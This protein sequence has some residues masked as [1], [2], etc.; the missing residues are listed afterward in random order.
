MFTFS[1]RRRLILAASLLAASS[2]YALHSLPSDSKVSISSSLVEG[3]EDKIFTDQSGRQISLRGFNVSG[4]VKLAESGFKAFKTAQDAHDSLTLLRQKTGANMIRYTIA[5]EGVQPS[6][7]GVDES[8]LAAVAEQIAIAADLGLYVLIDYH[9]DLY[10]RHTFTAASSDTGNGAPAWAVSDVYGKDD[11]G[12]PCDLTWA[13][14]KQSDS[15]VRNAMRS[16]WF[17]HWALNQD[18]ADTELFMADVAQ[19]VDVSSAAIV[20]DANIITWS[21]HNAANQRWHYHRDATLRSAADGNFCIDAAGGYSSNGT[22]IQLYQ[23][24]SSTA[25]KF[26]L[27]RHGRLHSLLDLNKCITRVNQNLE[28]AECD[29]AASAAEQQFV[30]RDGSSDAVLAGDL[31]YVQ[32]QFVWQLGEMLSYLQQHLTS[33]QLAYIIGVDPI[34]EPFDGGTGAMSYA[35][36]DNYVLWPF[37]EKVRAEMDRRGWSGTPVYAEPNV[38]WSSIAG[39][40]APATGGHYLAYQPGDGFVF[41]SHFY[42][43]G[44]MGTNDLSVARNGSYFDNLDLI[45]NEARY[46]N[47]APF[48]SEFGMWLDGW[49]HT[50]TSRIVNATYQG[51]ESS[52]SARSKD[53]YLNFYTPLISGSQ[54]QWDYYYDNHYELQNGNEEQV[55]TE[56]DA[57]NGENFSVIA[58]YGQSYNLDARLLERAYPR[59]VQGRLLHFAYSGQVPDEAG[60]IMNWYSIRASLPGYFR[61]REFLR[62]SIFAF[63]AWRGRSSE[64]PTEIYWPRHRDSGQLTLITERLIASGSELSQTVQ[65]SPDEA[66][67]VADGSA[68]GGQRLLVWDDTSPEENEDSLHFALLID[69]T[70]LSAS[71]LLQL[72]QAIVAT[73]ASE[74]SPVYLTGAMTHSGYGEDKGTTDNGFVLVNADSGLCLDVAGA[75]S[76]NGTNVQ[77]YTC[78]GTQ[79]QRWFY[80]EQSG[81]LRSAL[82]TSKCLDNGGQM[83]DGGKAVLWTCSGNNMRWDRVGKRLLPRLNSGFALHAEGVSASSDVRLRSISNSSRQQWEMQY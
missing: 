76:W 51:M 66:V 41:N 49:G 44:R 31:D 55:R 24:N 54:W 81:Y 57:W 60:E 68:S 3:I 13:A 17:D 6:A 37:Y 15:A 33:E 19:C 72:Q 67:L 82:N 23:C 32:S 73:L 9:S 1:M 80:D 78:N 71:E 69:G 42:D 74:Q 11:C 35:D 63:A 47:I 40:V 18:L 61:D 30:L 46:L 45:R 83:Y 26:A 4:E 12:L 25:Q 58:N 36:W 38:F 10:S 27:D 20:N 64:A 52:D 77:S 79:A 7:G 29:A 62:D 22:N 28:L 50:D 16:F 53:R 43:Q 21:C 48:L 39:A 59:A 5:W 70:D 75:R 8:Y 2:S 56:D 14:H 34:N 65:Q